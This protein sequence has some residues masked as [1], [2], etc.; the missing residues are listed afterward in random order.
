MKPP[1][2]ILPCLVLTILAAG[3]VSALADDWYNLTPGLEKWFV[4]DGAKFVT[5]RMHTVVMHP[6]AG[7]RVVLEELYHNDDLWSSAQKRYSFNL[8]GDVFFHGTLPER[9]DDP[10]LWVD[11]PLEVGKTWTDNRPNIAGNHDPANLIHYIFAVLEESTIECPAGTYPCYRVF[12]TEI[13]PTGSIRTECFWYNAQCGMVMCSSGE[14]RIYKLQKAYINGDYDTD[15]ERTDQVAGPDIGGIQGLFAAPNPSNPMTSI[16]FELRNP[17]VVEVGIFDISGRLVKRV[18][19]G[20]YLQ[21]GPVSV[22]WNGTDDSGRAVAS[23]TY[24]YRVQAG[25]TVRSDRI[26]LVR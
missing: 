22:R 8:E 18:V 24:F 25:Q 2:L 20:D 1:K 11:A 7:A 3:A 6:D 26:T 13:H 9:F 19:A 15:V 23:G 14:N 10:V 21:A 17:A 4:S 5:M 12:L 16:G